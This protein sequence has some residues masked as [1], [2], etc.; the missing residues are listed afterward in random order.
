[1]IDYVDDVHLFYTN[2]FPRNCS[3]NI[4]SYFLLGLLLVGKASRFIN[5]ISW[6]NKDFPLA[7]TSGFGLR[8]KL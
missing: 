3:I 1:M 8:Q 7:Y 2:F 4:I 6:R 5:F